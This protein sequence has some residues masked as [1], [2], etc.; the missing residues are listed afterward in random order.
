MIYK[1]E[2]YIQEDGENRKYPLKTIEQLSSMDGTDK[3]FIG[4]VSLAM[5]TPMG[6]TTVPVSFEIEG[7]SIEEAFRKFEA[8]AE[9]EVE[10]AKND[11]RDQ[12]QELRRKAQSRIVTPGEIPPT[13]LGKL[14]L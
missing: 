8:K 5:Q 14:K 12:L 11:L 13:D 4:R 3:R 1:R 7:A 9:E 2:E 10:R 6:V